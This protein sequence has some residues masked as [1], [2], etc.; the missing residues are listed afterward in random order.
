MPPTTAL[1]SMDDRAARAESYRTRA[2]ELR[3]TAEAMKDPE[4]RDKLLRIVDDYLRM[5]EA[6]ENPGSRLAAFAP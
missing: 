5:A 4:A 1:S 2:K 6:V 3:A